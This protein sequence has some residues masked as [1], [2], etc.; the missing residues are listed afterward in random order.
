MPGQIQEVYAELG[1][2]LNHPEAFGLGSRVPRPLADTLD[3]TRRMLEQAL[4]ERQ[5]P[6]GDLEMELAQD[7]DRDAL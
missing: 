5:M 1:Q 2:V 6:D 3:S 7:A 4:R